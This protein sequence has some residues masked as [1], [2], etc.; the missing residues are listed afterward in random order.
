MAVISFDRVSVTYAGAEAPVLDRV[1]FE[2]RE[3]VGLCVHAKW[4]PAVAGAHSMII[5]RSGA[6]RFQKS[7][8]NR[9]Q[10]DADERRITPARCAPCRVWPM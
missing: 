5:L 3:G 1:S 6:G 8:T 9:D 2:L 10:S 4:A 7:R